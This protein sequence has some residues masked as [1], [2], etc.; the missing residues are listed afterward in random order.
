MYELRP[1]IDW[2]KGSAFSWL[3][4]AMDF[5][6]PEIFPFYIGDDITDE[7]AFEALVGQGIGIVVGENSGPR[8]LNSG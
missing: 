4:D 8:K 2:D 5:V 1:D 6:G 7:D 3:L